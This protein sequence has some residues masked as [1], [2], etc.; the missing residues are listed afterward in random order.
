MAGEDLPLAGKLL[1]YRR[2][3][4]TAGDDQ[5]ADA[6]SVEAA[7]QVGCLIVQAMNA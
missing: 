2:H 3:R 7:E 1:G 6:H 5:L 4:S